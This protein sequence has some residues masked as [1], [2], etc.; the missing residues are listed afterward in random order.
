MGLI[1][2]GMTDFMLAGGFGYRKA[3]KSITF[4]GATPD[5]IGEISGSGDPTNLFTVTGIV[6]VKIIAVCTTNLTFDAN[7]TIEVGIGG[8][9]EIIATTDLTVQA[10]TAKE[11]WHD[12]TPDAEIEALSVIKEFIIT[13]GN[14]IQLDADVADTKTGVIEFYCFWTPV[15]SD[16]NVVAA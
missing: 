14:D 12:A 7:A 1:E 9:S 5:G 15:S 8:G 11:I 10:M 16:G 3:F 6:I 2:R 4:D 13:D